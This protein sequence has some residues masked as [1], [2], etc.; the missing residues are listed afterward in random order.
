MPSAPFA[1]A[2]RLL[3]RA[4]A[5]ALIGAS[6]STVK[7]LELTDPTFPR[8]VQISPRR[9]GYRADLLTAWIEARPRRAAGAS[10]RR[11]GLAAQ[12]A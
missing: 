12:N 7:R 2:P 3:S 10:L 4:E 11:S 5:A 1:E 8:G 9:I 6:P